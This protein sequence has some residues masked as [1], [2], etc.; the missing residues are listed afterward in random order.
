MIVMEYSLRLVG[1][2]DKSQD[3]HAY[4]SEVSI[5]ESSYDVTLRKP[6]EIAE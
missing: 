4:L 3:W 6:G 5:L 1:R 2:F